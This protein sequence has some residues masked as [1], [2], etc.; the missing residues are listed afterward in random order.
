[1]LSLVRSTPSDQ[2]TRSSLI[3]T[4]AQSNKESKIRIFVQKFIGIFEKLVPQENLG[5]WSRLEFRRELH[6]SD[7]DGRVS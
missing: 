3:G 2:C 7:L 6:S 5:E 4:S 1:M